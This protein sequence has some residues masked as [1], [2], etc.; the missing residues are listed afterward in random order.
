VKRL[1]ADVAVGPEVVARHPDPDRL[2]HPQTHSR[3]RDPEPLPRD[4]PPFTPTQ[5]EMRQSGPEAAQASR[6][7]VNREGPRRR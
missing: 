6:P 4:V 3:R 2:S 5:T 7:H 1:A